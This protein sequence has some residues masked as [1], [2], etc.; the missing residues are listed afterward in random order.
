MATGQFLGEGPLGEPKEYTGWD[1]YNN[2]AGKIDKELVTKWA[3]S[4]NFLL[5]FVSQPQKYLN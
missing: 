1:V 3:S 5:I 4:L 2:E